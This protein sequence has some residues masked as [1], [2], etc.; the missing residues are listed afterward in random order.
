MTTPRLSDA[1]T[2]YVDDVAAH[3]GPLPAADRRAALADLRDLLAE[4]M[5]PA[6]LGPAEEYA[7]A[8]G[9]SDAEPSE[10]LG[11]VL[12]VPVDV[13]AP[14]NARV[15]SRIFDPSDSRIV[16]P[17]VLGAG[18]RLNY[19]AIAV[20]LGLI[21]PDDYDEEVLNHIP[22]GVNA[23]TRALPWIVVGKTAFWAAVAWRTGEKVPSNWDV[24]G[25]V[26]GWSDRRAVLP[27]LVAVATGAAWWS[28]RADASAGDRLVRQALAT[29]TGAATTAM[30][31]IT[32]WTA[33]HPD[34]R[35][36]EVAVA[37]IAPWVVTGAMLVF[38][39]RAGLR[40][41]AAEPSLSRTSPLP[42]SPTP[43]SP[44]PQKDQS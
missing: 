44:T 10:T 32:A 9:A 3:L 11:H 26:A 25:R 33:L 28:T 35:H 15:R 37:A 24:A 2:R 17:R 12:G 16:V 20:R 14:T 23:V 7:A 19:G 5:E 22:A 8:L 38:P 4:G 1:A 21:R 43:Q 13:R 39:V 36:P 40:A 6:E 18:W 42:Q 34:E 31:V 27:A 41:L 30:A 29:S